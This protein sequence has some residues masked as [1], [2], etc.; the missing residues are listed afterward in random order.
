MTRLLVLEGAGLAIPEVAVDAVEEIDEAGESWTWLPGL[1]AD[2]AHV[3]REERRTIRLRGGGQVEVP[4][5]MHILEDVEVLELPELLRSIA[6]RNGVVGIASLPDGLT[7]V[8]DPRTL[9]S[10]AISGGPA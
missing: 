7:L 10:S 4:A 2:R 5:A 9:A 6:L 8:C 1:F 3:S